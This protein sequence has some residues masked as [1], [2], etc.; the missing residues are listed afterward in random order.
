[1]KY[2]CALG[3][4]VLLLG[5]IATPAVVEA[6]G[7]GG[8]GGGGFRGGGD[9]SGGGGAYRFSSPPA[10]AAPRMDTAPIEREASGAG[11]GP[12]LVTRMRISRSVA[13]AL[14]YSITTSK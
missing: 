12:R 14:A 11:S 9:F 10:E 5:G 6:R 4:S 2:W 1:M 7:G 8:G 13:A 3:V